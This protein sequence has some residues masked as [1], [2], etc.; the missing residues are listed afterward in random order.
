MVE[1]ELYM[2]VRLHDGWCVGGKDGSAAT[3][4]ED[5]EPRVIY[6]E[7]VS[8]QRSNLRACGRLH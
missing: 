2:P 1:D 5:G 6:S 7:E 8:S 3:R 4:I